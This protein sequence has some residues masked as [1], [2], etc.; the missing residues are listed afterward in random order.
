M[1]T[2]SPGFTDLSASRMMPEMKLATIFC[3]PIPIPT[4]TAPEKIASA[5]R[6]MP[7]ALSAIAIAT[8]ISPIRIILT[9]STWID[10]VRSAERLIRL[11]T[12]LLAMLVSHSASDQQR[13]EL[14]QQQRRQPQAAEHDRNRVQRLDGRLELADD[15][16]RRDQPGRQRHQPDDEGVA[17]HRGNEPDD[18][19]GEAQAW[20]RPRADSCGSARSRPA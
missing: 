6:L 20:R 7:T 8:T 13:A 14:D 19:P 18:Q 16:Q 11:S 12:K 15:A 1:V 17:D 9:S 2:R 4:P 10:G 5:E 3:R